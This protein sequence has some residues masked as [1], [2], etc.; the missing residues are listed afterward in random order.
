MIATA[1][2]ENVTPYHWLLF[3]ICFL[4]TAFAGTISTLMSVYLPVDVK[5][6]LGN[7]NESELNNISAYINAVFILGGSFG[8]FIAGVISDKAGR[9]TGV[10]F[11][12]ACYGVFTILTGYMPNWWGVVICRF[13]S[14]FGLG[15]VLV[16]TTTI[17]ME[18]WPKKSRA[19]FMGFLSISI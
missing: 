10:I 5:D 14:G 6:L 3:A 15:G 16:T 7:K 18:E 1:Q 2:E 9:K 11:S 8:G 4:G 17:M 13:F 19:I 12:I